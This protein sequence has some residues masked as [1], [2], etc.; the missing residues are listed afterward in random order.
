MDDGYTTG[1]VDMSRTLW[2]RV[3]QAGKNAK[4]EEAYVEM[5]D[6]LTRATPDDPTTE[7]HANVT[8]SRFYHERDNLTA[9]KAYMDKTA[10]IPEN[11]WWTAGPFDNTAGIGYNKAYIPENATQIDTETQYDGIDGQ[12]GWKKQADDV[13]DGFVNFQRIFDRGINWNTAYAW[14][15]VNS[16]DARKAELRFGS[17]NQ[18][19]LWVNGEAVFTHKDT[20]AAGIDQDTIPITL[21]QGENSILVK[22][23]SKDNYSLGFYLRITDP[24]GSPFSDLKFSDSDEN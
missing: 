3:A 24:D 17:G 4:D 7:L 18:T 8:L 2:S 16:P 23:C 20:H 19:K 10:F 22:V 12:V 6:E 1:N 14:T 9:A 13:I 21:K 15:P 11:A 5:V